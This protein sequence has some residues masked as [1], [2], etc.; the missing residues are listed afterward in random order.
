MDKTETCFIQKAVT[1]SATAS[2][3]TGFFYSTI[4][5]LSKNKISCPFLMDLKE[6][7]EETDLGLVTVV[8]EGVEE[9]TTC[10]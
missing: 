7:L 3:K 8:D 6:V 4:V 2:C 9:P 5:I 1:A 10:S